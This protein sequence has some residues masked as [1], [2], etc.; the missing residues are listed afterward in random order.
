MTR[1][2]SLSSPFVSQRFTVS[3]LAQI[4]PRG[5]L[6]VDAT[7]IKSRKNKWTMEQKLRGAVGSEDTRK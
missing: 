4:N 2:S 1:V 5:A 6:R 3:P 7:K